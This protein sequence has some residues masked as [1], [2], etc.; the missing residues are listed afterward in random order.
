MELVNGQDFAV[1]SKIKFP[2]AMTVQALP[3]EIK[4]SSHAWRLKGVHDY[5]VVH[6]RKRSQVQ[7]FH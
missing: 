1:P 6:I 2:D 4:L 7:I 3:A 5:P